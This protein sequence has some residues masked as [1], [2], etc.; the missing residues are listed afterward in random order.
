MWDCLQEELEK[1][2]RRMKE[3][4]RRAKEAR[5]SGMQLAD[6]QLEEYTTLKNQAA[7]E[8]AEKQAV[9][10]HA[11]RARN[12][13]RDML[14]RY[15]REIAHPTNEMTGHRNVFCCS[16]RLQVQAKEAERAIEQT[17]EKIRKLAEREEKLTLQID[18]HGAKVAEG[19]AKLERL[20]RAKAED[21]AREK[22]LREECAQVDA[23]LTEAK[24]DKQGVCVD[25]PQLN[26]RN[27]DDNG[28]DDSIVYRGGART[29]SG[30]D[31]R[32][33]ETIVPGGTGTTAGPL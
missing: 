6:D 14:Q 4:E 12:N 27:K 15:V 1:T 21:E 33:I 8:T 18:T 9:L 26:K 25:P 13:L 28:V 10:D 11:T 5:G 23:K 32:G 19:Q 29:K 2:T 17:E 31:I 20:E 7:A 3:H 22:E 30:G 16:C 24:A